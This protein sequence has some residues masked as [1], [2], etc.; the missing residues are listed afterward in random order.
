MAPNSEHIKTDFNA[1]WRLSHIPRP[2]RLSF[3]CPRVDLSVF[4]FISN[5]LMVNIVPGV[6]LICN[7]ALLAVF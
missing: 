1:S 7:F 2:L 3:K 6:D 5:S 4:F